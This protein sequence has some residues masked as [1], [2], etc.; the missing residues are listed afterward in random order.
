MKAVRIVY[1]IMN[2]IM[3]AACVVLAILKIQSP[4]F[5]LY[6]IAPIILAGV[7]IAALTVKSKSDFKKLMMIILSA[8]ISVVITVAQGVFAFEMQAGNAAVIIVITAIL[9]AF[10]IW[11]VRKMFKKLDGFKQTETK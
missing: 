6:L 10:M 3:I 5:A 11:S 9:M 7:F 2:A 1:I 4:Q 8:H